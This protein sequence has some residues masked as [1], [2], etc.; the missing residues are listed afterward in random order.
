MNTVDARG[1]K[2][3]MPLI[4]T[5]KAITN[6]DKDTAIKVLIDN[7]TSF[8]NVSHF[9]SDNKIE[10]SSEQNGD[11]YVIQIN[12]QESNLEEVDAAAYCKPSLPT[13]NSFVVMFAKDRIGEGSEELGNVLVGG[14][15]TTIKERDVLPEKIILMNSGINLVMKDSPAMPLLKELEGKGVDIVSCGTCLDYYEK[16]D[17]LAVGRVSNMYEILESM[18]A[19]QKVINI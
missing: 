14:F 6:A 18:L 11:E 13:D 17:E 9:L 16:M 2:C 8:K 12:K 5:K 7:E 19:V 4:E 3:P 1:L 10:F 15:L